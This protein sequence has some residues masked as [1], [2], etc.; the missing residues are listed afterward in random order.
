MRGYAHCLECKD[1]IYSSS[2]PGIYLIGE[3]HE[4]ALQGSVNSWFT[5]YDMTC[6]HVNFES[7]CAECLFEESLRRKNPFSTNERC[8]GNEI[9]LFPGATHVF[10]TRDFFH[11]RR[12]GVCNQVGGG[13]KA[14][15]V[16]VQTLRCFAFSFPEFIRAGWAR[17]LT[18]GRG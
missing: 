11:S 1:G 14:Q 13:S 12:T 8:F 9:R 3:I 10:L 6:E 4:P 16:Q 5:H 2:R 18:S 17:T 15:F 7:L